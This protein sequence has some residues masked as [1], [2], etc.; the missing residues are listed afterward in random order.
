MHPGYGEVL[1]QFDGDL[2]HA[3][4]FTLES[5]DLL[6]LC[7]FLFLELLAKKKGRRPT[8]SLRRRSTPSGGMAKVV[9]DG[10]NRLVLL[11][12]ARHRLHLHGSLVLD[13]WHVRSFFWGDLAAHLAV[14]FRNS[15]NFVSLKSR[16][17]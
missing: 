16:I 3:D 15:Q 13:S 11:E 14:E 7:L 4:D 5:R 1:H 9:A 10:G 12:E 17:N 8:T 2:L 6:V